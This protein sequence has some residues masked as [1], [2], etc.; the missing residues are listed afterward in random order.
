MTIDLHFLCMS[1]LGDNQLC[2]MSSFKALRCSSSKS[3]SFISSAV[4]LS[5][6]SVYD[7]IPSLNLCMPGISSSFYLLLCLDCQLMMNSCGC[8]LYGI[9]VLYQ[10]IHSGIL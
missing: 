9:L 1:I 6:K 4:M 5:G 3:D 2:H 8:G 7:S 10:Y